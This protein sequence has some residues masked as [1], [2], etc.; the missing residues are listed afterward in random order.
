M[1]LFVTLFLFFRAPSNLGP[2][3]Y[4]ATLFRLLLPYRYQK[5]LPVRS[6]VDV[7]WVLLVLLLV[8]FSFLFF[9]L[10]FL[11]WFPLSK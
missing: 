8:P 5:R 10:L 3:R 7:S 4:P 9:A 2:F 11:K 1:H 6:K